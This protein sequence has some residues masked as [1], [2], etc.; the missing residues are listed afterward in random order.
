MTLEEVWAAL[1]GAEETTGS[2]GT[3]VRQ[4]G[5]TVELRM[6][7]GPGYERA[8]LITWSTGQCTP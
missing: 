5:I 2:P 1:P 6:D 4:D 3:A 8:W 7:D